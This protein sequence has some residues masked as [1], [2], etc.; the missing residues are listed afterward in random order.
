M[1]AA[2]LW[3]DGAPATAEGLARQAL[4]NYGAYTSFA[5]DNGAVRGLDRHMA[6]LV[7]SAEALFGEAVPEGEIRRQLRLALGDRPRGF[8]RISLFSPD[9]SPR[10]PDVEGRPSVMV[11]VFPPVA[12]LSGQPLR[13][14]VQ[15]YAREAA[16]LKHVATFGLIRARRLARRD[17]FDDALLADADGRVSEGTLWN[18]GFLEGDTVVWPDAPMLAG[19]SQALIRDHL[20][21][22]GLGQTTRVIRVE[23]LPRF[24]GAFITNSATPACAVGA[25]DGHTYG[26]AGDRVARVAAAWALAA[27][28]P[29]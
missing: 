12:P 18:I 28:Q 27:P 23:D 5:V 10:T 25:I 13:L 20:S 17:G 3:I 8:A 26:D 4:V 19:V 21:E 11:G 1:A 6:R 29:V 14:Q 7:R 15:A 9:I 22:V 2:D 16:D 24:D